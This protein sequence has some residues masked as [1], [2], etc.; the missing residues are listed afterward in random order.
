MSPFSI[1][2]LITIVRTS[3]V[4]T[5]GFLQCLRTSSC[6]RQ[7]LKSAQFHDGGRTRSCGPVS[8]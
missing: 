2:R 3:D 8:I 6:Y 7:K 1:V 5:G 4:E